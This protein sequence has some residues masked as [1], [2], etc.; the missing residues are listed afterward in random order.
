M[1]DGSLQ[2]PD[3]EK[4]LDFGFS[5][6][7]HADGIQW[8]Q[9]LSENIFGS[10]NSST[11]DWSDCQ[12]SQHGGDPSGVLGA[13]DVNPF[14]SLDPSVPTLSDL[15]SFGVSPA[16]EPGF[17]HS[18]FSPALDDYALLIFDTNFSVAP[19]SSGTSS[20][21]SHAQS[22]PASAPQTNIHHQE[23]VPSSANR[24]HERMMLLP[25]LPTPHGP[26]RYVRDLY[27]L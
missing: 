19:H 20:H 15:N 16:I 3:L 27:S 14:L 18:S 25:P 4:C 2:L 1:H 17:D 21:G 9:I 12:I 13:A 23:P 24:G 7:D 11:L 6:D 22:S 26:R 10:E 5:L 8:D